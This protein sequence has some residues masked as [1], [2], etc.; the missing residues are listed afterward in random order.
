MKLI[1]SIAKALLLARWKQTLVAAVGVTFSIAMFIALLSFMGG[2]NK[3]LDGLMLNRTAHVR[4]FNDTKANKNQ[5]INNIDSFKKTYNFIQSVKTSNTREGI[6]NSTAI[7]EALKRDK[8]ILGAVPKITTSVFFN[9]VSKEITGV[10]NGIEIESE[11]KLFHISEYIIKGNPYDLERQSNSII[12]GSGLAE[13]L[14]VEIGDIVQISAISGERFSLKVVGIYQSGVA[15]FDKI[16][17]Y[18]S[19]AT[20]QKLLVKPN[21]FYTDIQIKLKDIN[22]APILAKQFSKIFNIDAEDIFTANAQLSTGSSVRNIISWAVGIVLLIVAGFG[23]YNILNMMIYEKMESIAILK[24]T[25]F[26]GKD[27]KKIFLIIALGIGLFGGLLGLVFGFGISSVIDLIPFNTSALPSVETYPVDYD[28][29]FYVIGIVFSLITTYFAGW[30]PSRKASKVDP[31][32][33]IR[34]K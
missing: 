1:V 20:V 13:V 32:I 14:L 19:I 25:G 34:G 26:T 31:V 6:Y 21:S 24:A 7:I 11:V 29:K 10:V 17:S 30:L 22:T 23:I 33:I 4:L 12:L 8:N 18:T 27:V 2:L 9:D 3:L 5:P 16:Q 28:I 15:G